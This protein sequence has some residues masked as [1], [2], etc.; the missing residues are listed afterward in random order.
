MIYPNI[1]RELKRDG[2]T[3]Y[4]SLDSLRADGLVKAR[5]YGEYGTYIDGAADVDVHTALHRLDE[6]IGKEGKP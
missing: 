4:V 5:L 2:G 1:D 6:A 3:G